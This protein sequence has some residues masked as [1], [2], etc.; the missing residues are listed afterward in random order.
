MSKKFIIIVLVIL[1]L[2]GLGF[3]FFKKS[4]TPQD[5]TTSGGFSDFFNFGGEIGGT[6]SSK[7]NEATTTEPENIVDITDQEEVPVV[8][9]TELI[10]KLQKITS[11]NVAG[12]TVVWKTRNIATEIINAK[13]KKPETEEFLS[14]L[15]GEKGTGNIFERDLNAQNSLEIEKRI[16]ISNI[17]ETEKAIFL[18][19]GKQVILQYA[20]QNSASKTGFEIES[21]LGNIPTNTVGD[22][23]FSQEIEGLFMDK[24]IYDISILK[25][26]IFYLV[27]NSSGVSGYVFT[28]ASKTKSLVFSSPFKGFVS[29]FI[30][31]KSILLSTK[32]TSNLKSFVYTIDTGTKTY[33]KVLGGENGLVALS[34]PGQKIIAISDNTLALKYYDTTLRESSPAGTKTIASKCA[35]SQK[36]GAV[37]FCAA[38]RTITSQAFPDNWY[39]GLISF[40]DSFWKLNSKTGASEVLFDP[41]DFDIEIDGQKL[42]LDDKESRLF[43]IN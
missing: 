41:V 5:D 33:K 23:F 36:D 4:S 9:T 35:W 27:E 17:P 25:D 30:S 16:V 42:F 12:A 28:P 26:K 20:K 19:N 43:F 38:P 13:T 29:Q 11:L 32:A 37:L 22:N 34:S 40:N 10:K 7:I 1:I 2:G 6:K 14:I 24:N 15:Y 31:D 18:N 3:Y 21:F 39:Q 8:A